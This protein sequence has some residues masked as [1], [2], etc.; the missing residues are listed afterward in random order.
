LLTVAVNPSSGIGGVPLTGTITLSAAAPIGGVTVALE[1]NDASVQVPA[2]V[3]VL[4]GRTTMDF[5]INTT[6][7]PNVHAVTITASCNGVNRTASVTLNPPLMLTL[8]TSTTTGGNNVT[9]T[10][11]VAEA[12]PAGGTTVTLTTS[13]STVARILAPVNILAGQ[14]S[15]KF[16]VQT[17]TTSADRTVSITANYR[18]ASQRVTLTVTSSM[19]SGISKLEITPTSVKGGVGASGTVTL[20]GPAG[21]GGVL[22]SL[23]SNNILAASVPMFVSVGSGQSSAQFSIRTSSVMSPQ[24]VTITATTGD[25]AKSATLLVN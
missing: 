5:T 15:A 1:S 24:T 10:V 12:A 19:A 21:I 7:V 14:T 18:G 20:S 23:T 11:T 13:D 3:A 9:G 16:N 8:D 17:S 25:T 2:T 4:G 22:V 6:A